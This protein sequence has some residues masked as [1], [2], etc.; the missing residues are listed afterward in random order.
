MREIAIKGACKSDRSLIAA[1]PDR[2]GEEY[3]GQCQADP[4]TRAAEELSRSDMCH[5]VGWEHIWPCD[6]DSGRGADQAGPHHGSEMPSV[7]GNLLDPSDRYQRQ[8]RP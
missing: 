8:G 4:Q 1:Q 5:W 6:G 3:R 2:C 7:E